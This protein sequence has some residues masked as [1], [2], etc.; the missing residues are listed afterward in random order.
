MPNDLGAQAAWDLTKALLRVDTRNLPGNES[1]AVDVVE[2]FLKDHGVGAGAGAGPAPTRVGKSAARENLVCRLSG[3][4]GNGSI[5]LA[6]HLDTVPADAADWSEDPLGAV[7]KDGFLYGRGVLDMKGMAAMC[8]VIFAKAAAAGT[9]DA[10]LVLAMVAD[11][12]RGGE[13]GS[14]YLVEHHADLVVAD[15]MIGE[16]GGAAQYFK[17]RKFYPV[18]CA[19]KGQVIVRLFVE[20][21]EGHGST[22]DPRNTGFVLAKVLRRLRPGRFPYRLTPTAK[23][24]LEALAATQSAPT[25]WALR[26]LAG[27]A[28]AAVLRAMPEAQ[29]GKLR[30]MLTNTVSPTR[31]KGA[32]AANVIPRRIAVDLDCRIL[33]GV[34]PEEF[35]R[36]LWD[37]LGGELPHE[38]LEAAEGVESSVDTPLLRHLAAKTAEHDPGAPVV[39]LLIPGFTDAHFFSRLGMDCYGFSPLVMGPEEASELMRRIH[40]RDERVSREAFFKGYALLEDAVLSFIGAGTRK[41]LEKQA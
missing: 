41:S 35:L 38:I 23:V 25:S 1:K 16:G 26:A 3:H 17:G 7:E 11:E 33:P 37:A 14:R 12:E 31:F 32:E 20:G 40:G 19:E 22:P 36:E 2:A 21:L 34:T 10:D 28:G 30:P 18:G 29:A 4:T 6:G 39:P 9:P 13:F 27:G 15:Y 24:F 5:L 8:A